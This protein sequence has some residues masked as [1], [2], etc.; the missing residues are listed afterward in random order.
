MGRLTRSSPEI[1][2]YPEII[3]NIWTNRIMNQVKVRFE[4]NEGYPTI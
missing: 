3:N 2:K 4:N 1:S